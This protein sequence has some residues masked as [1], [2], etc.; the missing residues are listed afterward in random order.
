[1]T[2]RNEQPN[3]KHCAAKTD[4]GGVTKT[5]RVVVGMVARAALEDKRYQVEVAPA[6]VGVHHVRI[7]QER[8]YSALIER[9]MEVNGWRGRV[10][11]AWL[12]G[13][14]SE[15]VCLHD[16]G[17]PTPAIPADANNGFKCSKVGSREL[18]L[19]VLS[20]FLR[21]SSWAVVAHP[22]LFSVG[23]CRRGRLFHT[24][25]FI[26]S[27]LSCSCP[28]L[29]HTFSILERKG[30]WGCRESRHTCMPSRIRC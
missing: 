15:S 18:K 25:V 12:F 24:S 16:D 28:P 6:V 14:E 30:S 5:A 10:A 2:S 8:T 20:R 21:T 17:E 13:G 19:Q 27:F 7:S 1:M 22:R 11:E 26:S 3:A 29:P 4:E 9:I 23:I